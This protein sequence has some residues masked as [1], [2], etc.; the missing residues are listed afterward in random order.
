MYNQQ[1]TNSPSRLQHAYLKPAFVGNQQSLP[2]GAQWSPG[3]VYKTAHYAVP[4]TVSHPQTTL[5]AGVYQTT[6]HGIIYAG[7]AQYGQNFVVPVQT[8]PVYATSG[9]PQHVVYVEPS[10]SH[11]QSQHYSSLIM[12]NNNVMTMEQ[13]FQLFAQ[14]LA[15]TYISREEDI[16]SSVKIALQFFGMCF[17]IN[18]DF[19]RNK[20]ESKSRYDARI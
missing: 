2:Y 18:C 17:V 19:K 8:T 11:Q 3:T 16:P 4:T 20:K 12:P 14:M 1:K 9:T 10:G 13:L 5:S 7:H 15:Y 6:P